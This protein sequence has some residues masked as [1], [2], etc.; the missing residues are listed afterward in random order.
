MKHTDNTSTSPSLVLGQNE[1]IVASPKVWAVQKANDIIHGINLKLSNMF[2]GFPFEAVG[3]TWNDSERLYLLGEFSNDTPEH[4]MIQ[5]NLLTYNNGSA[6]KRFGKSKYRKKVRE[7]FGGDF[8]LQ[9]MQWVVWQK[10]KGNKD[11]QELLLKVPSDVYLLE[12]TSTDTGG[13]AEVWGCRNKELTKARKAHIEKVTAA[14]SHLTKKAL[15]ALLAVERNKIDSVG[16]WTGQNNMGKI[17]MI[18]RNCIIDGTE[19]EIDFDLLRSKKIYILG[20]LL[21]F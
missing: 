11:F 16:T 17:L 12:N 1:V 9:W 13:S 4:R 5:E 14:N 20:N 21:T 18:C 19:P 7:D 3:H 6:A 2:T 8:R 10:T 15:D